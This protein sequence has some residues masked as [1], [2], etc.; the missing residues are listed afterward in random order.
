[1]KKCL[2][3]R[4]ICLT[5]RKIFQNTPPLPFSKKLQK[6]LQDIKK[7]CIFAEPTKGVLWQ[8]QSL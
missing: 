3:F 8:Q 1:M 2:F 4:K 5:L 7:S 6:N